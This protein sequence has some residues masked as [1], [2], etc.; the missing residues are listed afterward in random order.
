MSSALGGEVSGGPCGPTGS[1]P[2][3]S[4]PGGLCLMEREKKSRN[5]ICQASLPQRFSSSLSTTVQLVSRWTHFTD[6]QPE[7]Q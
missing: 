5:N 2:S 6:Q 3:L 7:A 1:F 4:F